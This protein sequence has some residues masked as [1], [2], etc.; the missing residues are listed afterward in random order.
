MYALHTNELELVDVN[1]SEGGLIPKILD[2][3]SKLRVGKKNDSAE[4]INGF[5]IINLA[6]NLQ[7]LSP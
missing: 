6:F 2:W 1:R 4:S 5:S 3:P 7:M